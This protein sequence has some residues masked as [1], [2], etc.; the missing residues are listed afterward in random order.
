MSSVQ[1]Q[2]NEVSVSRQRALSFISPR[3]FFPSALS[4][5]AVGSAVA[6]S[7]AM[8]RN[9][10]AATAQVN[11]EAALVGEFLS[12]LPPKGSEFKGLR[13]PLGLRLEGRASS[14]VS[15]FLDL[16]YNG[17]QYP[18]I[19]APLGNTEDAATGAA[20]QDVN[21]PFTTVGGRGEKRESL[22]VNQA[23]VQ[24]DS[25]DA[26]RFRAGR[27]PRHWGLGL[28]L[29][30]EWKPEGGSRST[31]D[32]VSYTVD[33]PSALSATAYWE[34][35]SEG[36]LSAHSDDADAFTGE[37]LISDELTDGSSSGLSRR[38]GL[39]FSKYD[40]SASSTEL[41]ILDIFGVFSFGRVGIEGELNWPTGKT[42]SLKYAS[43]GGD[44]VS[45]DNSVFARDSQTIEGLNVLLRARYQLGGGLAAA[46]K[47]IKISQT[48][49]ARLRR[50]TSQTTE[51]QILTLTGGF[52]RG[53]SDA[54]DNVKGKDTKIT[55]VP[56]HP[57]V[58]PALLMFS[59][60]SPD[61]AGMPGAIVRNVL[62][63]RAE[64]S[65]ESP[66]FGMLTPSLVFARL[67]QTNTKSTVGSES[68]VGKNRNLGFE[69]DISYS[70]RTMDGVRFSLDG[71]LWLPGGAWEVSGVKPETVYGLRAT[72]A[73]YF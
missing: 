71:G 1:L 65:Y 70:Y 22:K 36:S 10:C 11:G 59:P 51:S 9:A 64:Y 13:V 21:H 48:E 20:A 58:R 2:D 72:A 24:Y 62:F 54:F 27:I 14:N 67:D 49:A 30:D 68:V 44:S 46:D 60:L 17:N 73:T 47:S 39:A 38:L 52:S 23:F 57:N 28:W 5:C 50:P 43:L 42:R 26:G 4:L 55:A 61:T 41:K 69:V 37:I 25:A 32:A 33:F 18:N 12:G 35:V 19:A 56:M 31:S 15:V 3:S 29:D 66:S 53:D 7:A 16:R 6:L 34:K 40:H 45:G 63:A 8:S